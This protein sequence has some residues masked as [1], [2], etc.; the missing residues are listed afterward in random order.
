MSAA[1]SEDREESVRDRL[2]R[3]LPAALKARDRLAVAA[4]R[5]TLAAID[6]A[7]AVDATTATATAAPPL[8]SAPE[9]A[10]R[11][12]AAD[13]SPRP[14]PAPAAPPQEVAADSGDRGAGFAGSVV[15]LGAAE[16]ERRRL[17]N[18]QMEEIVRAEVDDRRAAARAYE[19]AGQHEHA[20]QLRAEAEL[21]SCY[22]TDSDPPR[23]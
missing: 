14:A 16:V 7:E 2:R 1:G 12:A 10:T 20:A 5:S 3:A 22:L 4:L 18:G 23:P 6:N 15:G 21:L 13:P 8:G 9:S 17:T 19:D 11:P